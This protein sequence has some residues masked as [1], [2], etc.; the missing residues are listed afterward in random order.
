[1]RETRRLVPLNRSSAVRVLQYAVVT[2]ALVWLLRQIEIRRVVRLL[3]DLELS[4]LLV[5]CLVTAVEFATRFGMWYALLHDRWGTSL[6]TA[7]RVDLVIKFVNHLVP[8][9]AAG[10]SVAPLV[11]R[12]YASLSWSEA[13]SVAGLNTALYALLYGLVAT[14]GLGLLVTSL[15]VGLLVVLALSTAIYLGVGIGVLVAG[16]NLTATVGPLVRIEAA[17]G[18]LPVVGRRAGALLSRVPD[19]TDESARLFRELAHRPRVLVPYTLGWLGTLFLAPGIRTALV[20]TATGSAF[21]PIWLVPFALVVAY[22]VTVLPITPGGVGVTEVSATLVFVSLGVPEEA[23]IA[24]VL[25]DR[26]LGVYLPAALGWIP[27][28]RLDLTAGQ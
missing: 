20:L 19:L 8:S 16:R 15:P 22:S 26:S 17:L 28:T 6:A 3:G 21:A 24:V 23:A 10:H 14:V 27:A 11:L 1:M 7:V 25:I 5:V 4:I 18:T 12:Q 2:L 9:K 13:L